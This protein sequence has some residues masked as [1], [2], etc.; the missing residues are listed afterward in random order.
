MPGKGIQGDG[1]PER[2]VARAVLWGLITERGGRAWEAPK[3]GGK[4]DHRLL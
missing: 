2:E 3:R 1:S 4:G